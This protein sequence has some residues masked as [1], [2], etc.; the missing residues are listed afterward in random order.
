MYLFILIFITYLYFIIKNDYLQSIM[1][2]ILAIS[3]W[4]YN[5]VDILMQC[6]H[7]ENNL[8]CESVCPRL[9]KK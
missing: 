9:Q 1:N 7:L 3:K 8:C 4:E 6:I 2:E 5:E